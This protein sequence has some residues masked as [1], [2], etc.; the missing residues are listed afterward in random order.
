MENGSFSSDEFAAFTKTVIPFLHVTTRIEG[1]END[2]LLTVYGGRG[3]P[4]MKFL[5]AEGKALADNN[6]RDVSGIQAV[7]KALANLSAIKQRIARGE[8]G[9]DAQLLLAEMTVGSVSLADAK[10]RL[11]GLKKL[12]PEMKAK[13]D[14]AM[15]NL[16]VD[17]ALNQLMSGKGDMDQLTDMMVK[18]A[19]EGRIPTGESAGFF[20]SLVTQWADKNGE[21]DL[22]EKGYNFLIKKYGKEEGA[23]E[24]FDKMKKRIDEL[25]KEANPD[26]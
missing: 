6:A 22:L 24:Y 21:V 16:E 23:G 1:R 12:K 4:T 25:K 20:W 26:A 17:E 18:M 10:K 3:F 7:A 15:I 2:D 19:K 11:A 9:L 13:L 14:G 8:K 5:D